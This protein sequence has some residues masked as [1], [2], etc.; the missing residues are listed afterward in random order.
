MT[1]HHESSESIIFHYYEKG[2][3]TNM[4]VLNV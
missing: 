3:E 4:L 1:P 2:R